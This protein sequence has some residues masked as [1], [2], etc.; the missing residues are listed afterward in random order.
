MVWKPQQNKQ[1]TMSLLVNCGVKRHALLTASTFRSKSY[2]IHFSPTA[3]PTSNYYYHQ[4]SLPK[5]LQPW[6]FI[7]KK[8]KKGIPKG[9]PGSSSK[10]PSFQVAKRR[11]HSSHEAP[12][13][14]AQSHSAIQGP[15]LVGTIGLSAKR[16]PKAA[17]SLPENKKN[18]GGIGFDFSDV[19]GNLARW[20]SNWWGVFVFF[21]CANIYE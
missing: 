17:S 13:P 14:K 4:G 16:R 6:H 8:G 10:H 1:I 12:S 7:P 9:K 20:T 21:C 5:I 2:A 3:Y 18:K 19:S 15:W 11:Q